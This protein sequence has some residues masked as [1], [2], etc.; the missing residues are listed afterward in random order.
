MT[1]QDVD[2]PLD[3]LQRVSARDTAEVTADLTQ[4]LL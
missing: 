3:P 1:G 2:V 4:K